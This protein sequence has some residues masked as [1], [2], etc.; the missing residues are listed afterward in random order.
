[1]ARTISVNWIDWVT[2][3]I[4]LVSILRGTRYG[5]LAGL[6]DL[7]ALAG[8]FFTAAVLYPLAIPVL[9][10][11]LYLPSEW[12]GF[13]AF[14]VIWLVIYIGIGIIIR[15]VHGVKTLPLSEML[16]GAFGLLRGLT[17]ATAC[18]VIM[19]AAP[20]HGA[21]D[22]DAKQSPV[23]GFLLRGY[24]AVMVTVVPTLPVRI[25]RIGPGG[26]AF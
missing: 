9:N 22:P 20:F 15:L 21:I 2:L 6:F 13:L 26:H 16:G 3:A 18:L 8:A 4:V 25:P 12:G 1:M 19:L 10:K 17:L 7:L 5:I 14:V 24:N 23:A 11:S